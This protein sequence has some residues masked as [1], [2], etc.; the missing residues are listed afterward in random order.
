MKTEK[1]RRTLGEKIYAYF[2]QR[3]RARFAVAHEIA[4]VSIVSIGNLTLGGTGKTPCVQ[5]LAARLRNDD[6]RPA[7]VARGYG[8]TLSGKGALVSDGRTIFLGA[9]QSGDEALLHARALPDVPVIIGRERK[10]A[11]ERARDLGCNIIVLDDG[12]QYWSLARAFD[13]VLLDARRPF[14]NE[15][16]LPRGRLREEIGEL[17]RANAVLF[18]ARRPRQRCAVATCA[19]RG[20]ELS[21]AGFH[22]AAF[23]AGIV[24]VEWQFVGRKTAIGV[25][26][27]T[28][29]VPIGDC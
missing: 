3:R 17:Q 24:G 2:L 20:R 23:A 5:W 27:K 7:I 22:R 13:L 1:L 9:H 4:D 10:N 28:S 19:R 15:R 14:D 21:I 12:F 11:V 25:E 8:G 16:L 26:R 29:R 6:F 18:N